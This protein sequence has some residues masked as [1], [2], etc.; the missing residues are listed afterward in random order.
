MIEAFVIYCQIANPAVCIEYR[1]VP[2]TYDPVASVTHCL[3]GGLSF[4]VPNATM[5]FGDEAYKAN[6]GVRC[7]ATPPTSGEIQAWVAEQK[8]RA[9][10]LKPQIR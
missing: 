7:R 8:A 5:V 4:M 1:I 3:R 9:E 2:E 6:G 10:R